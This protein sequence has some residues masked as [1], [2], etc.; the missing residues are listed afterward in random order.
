VVADPLAKR[1]VNIESDHFVD[2]PPGVEGYRADMHLRSVLS[3]RLADDIATAAH[4]SHTRQLVILRAGL[5][6]TI[7]RRPYPGMQLFEIDD[8]QTQQWKRQVLA[9]AG[10]DAPRTAHYIPFGP[11]RDIRDDDLDA[12]GYDFTAPTLVIWLED[13]SFLS[14][15]AI[16]TTFE[17][18]NRHRGR[19][20]VVFDY[21]QPPHAVAAS[22]AHRL[23]LILGTVAGAGMP[24]LS[25]FTPA[26]VADRLRRYGFHTTAEYTWDDLVDRYAP[27]KR[28]TVDP[29]GLRTVHTRRAGLGGESRR[30]HAV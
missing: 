2:M 12:A 9:D 30:P 15:L 3:H 7:Y 10:I 28:N 13:L 1:L 21:F 19:I 26:D 29:L 22:T 16:T 6:T 8:P 17:W 5:D 14:E 4:R 20:E 18:L 25:T 11:Q 27:F 23:S 24:V